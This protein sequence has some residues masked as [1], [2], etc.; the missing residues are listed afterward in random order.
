MMKKI[1]LPFLLL[2]VMGAA[3]A[4]GQAG[5]FASLL[6]SQ[7]ALKPE[8]A[9]LPVPVAAPAAERGPA[10]D[11]ARYEREYL[12]RRDASGQRIIDTLMYTPGPDPL[13]TMAQQVA[14]A[15]YTITYEMEHRILLAGAGKLPKKSVVL[16]RGQRIGGGMNVSQPGQVIKLDRIVSA[17]TSKEVAAGFLQDMAK[18]EILII[19][20]KSARDISPYSQCRVEGID[21]KEHFLMPASSYRVGRIYTDTVV[22]FLQSTGRE[23]KFKVRHVE[24]NE[25]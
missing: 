4:R 9:A 2:A 21:E 10:E 5:A 8:P 24:L 14:I 13:L 12:E 23:E 22:I 16:Y 1:L 19:K 18:A 25:L 11:Q 17:S 20:A 7:G 3:P 15:H 6:A